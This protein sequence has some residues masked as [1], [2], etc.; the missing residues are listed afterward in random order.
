MTNDVRLPLLAER[1][2]DT[3][4]LVHERKLRTVVAVMAP[5][6]GMAQ[7]LTPELMAAAD[8]PF[9]R[10]HG[11]SVDPGGY[12]VAV[13]PVHGTLVHRGGGLDAMSGLR[14]YEAIREDLREAIDNPMVSAILFDI[15]SAGGEASGCFDLVDEI[16]AARDMKPVYAFVNENAYSAAYAIASAAEKIYLPRTGG[17]GSVGVV[18][19]H[20]DESGADEKAGLVFTA[21]VAGR[22]KTE[23]WSKSP[24]T[25]EA[26][27][28]WQRDIDGIYEIFA[29]TVAENRGMA[30]ADVVATEAG[31]FMGQDAVAVGFADGIATLDDVIDQISRDLDNGPGAEK[32][33]R[34]CGG[35][36]VSGPA[37][38]DSETEKDGAAMA[39][40]LLKGKRRAGVK[41][42]AAERYEDEESVDR[43]NDDNEDVA[44]TEDEEDT[45]ETP[46]DE[47]AVGDDDDTDAEGVEDDD[48]LEA[49]D[50][51]EDTSA[52]K[53]AAN[54]AEIVDMCTLFGKP[55][56]ASGFIRKGLSASSV[57]K[58]LLAERNRESA[59]A[60]VGSGAVRTAHAG[61]S[62][63][64]SVREGQRLSDDMKRRF[65]GRK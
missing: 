4:L 18:R 60:T 3:P 47:N 64:Q 53:A 29:A 51:E 50:D 48:D 5:H 35:A 37:G 23:G 19:L 28:A 59:S 62:D 15:D 9:L 46:D 65:E 63:R 33:S 45:I 57:R 55:G 44:E 31:C 42:P 10:D 21:V 43:V 56:M 32:L 27:A 49:E 52:R 11:N 54:A 17:V 1:L 40:N 34:R 61:R 14:S 8:D 6:F 25:E 7:F 36:A 39:L 41:K 26:R 2:F 22:R 13:I 20:V 30:I 12:A 16:R 38:V 58:R 24:L